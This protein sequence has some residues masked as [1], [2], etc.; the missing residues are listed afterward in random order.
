MAEKNGSSF[1]VKISVGSAIIVVTAIVGVMLYLGDI[2]RCNAEQTKDIYYGATRTDD[3][4][5]RIRK[6][7]EYIAESREQRREI[8][9]QRSIL[10]RI[11]DTVERRGQ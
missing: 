3:Q 6:L 11:L 1:A 8:R 2:E 5:A 7:E 9:E 4:E 10:D